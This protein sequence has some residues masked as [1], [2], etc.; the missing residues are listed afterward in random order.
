MTRVNVRT[1]GRIPACVAMTCLLWTST[2]RADPFAPGDVFAA[3]G[4]GKVQ[5]YDGS[6]NLLETLDTGLGGVTAGMAFDSSGNLY[7]TAFDVLGP[8]GSVTKFAGPGDP[9]T[10]LGIFGSFPIG[11]IPNSILF[12]SS[13]NAYV[14]VFFGGIRKFDATGA[15]L[16]QFEAPPVQFF[17]DWIDLAVDQTTMFYTSRDIEQILRHDVGSDDP[18]ANFPF[19]EACFGARSHGL[20]LLPPRDGSGGLL[21]VHTGIVFRLDGSGTTVQTYTAPGESFF[22]L[23]LDPNGTSF[24]SGGGATSNFYRFNITTGTVE[25]GPIN[26]GAGVNVGGLV[27]FPLAD[28]D[29]DGD[30]IPDALDNCPTVFN[31]DQTDVN[32]DGVGDACVDGDGDGIPDVLDNCLTVFNPDQTDDNMDGF[33]D[34]CVSPNADIGDGVVLGDGVIIGDGA[35]IE[36]GAQIG[37]GAVIEDGATVEQGASVGNGSVI[38]SNSKVEISATVGNNVTVGS[39]TTIETDAVI[40]DGAV[41]GNDVTIEAGAVV[42][43][44]EVIPDGAVVSP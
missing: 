4:A 36:D 8:V 38:G 12:D 3:A 27:V 41:I 29:G 18:L 20:S 17:P 13:G 32:M 24:W 35:V 2:A 9:H 5:H 14:A 6:G 15:L 33:G 44:D 43:P 19:P 31:P 23:T 22:A 34:A 42:D 25:L 39:D 16:K 28:P 7:V 1:A 40:G 26:T 21:V 10:N 11:D 37:D 30:G